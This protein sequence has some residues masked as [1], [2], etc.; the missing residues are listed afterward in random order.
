MGMSQT[1]KHKKRIL[2]ENEVFLVQRQKGLNGAKSRV[3][4]SEL[5]KDELP[6]LKHSSLLYLRTIM[7][8][9]TD[10]VGGGEDALSFLRTA[11]Q[12]RLVRPQL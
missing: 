11:A 7:T 2:T 6:S 1:M 4:L 9:G 12:T 3:K 8:M 10:E 5:F